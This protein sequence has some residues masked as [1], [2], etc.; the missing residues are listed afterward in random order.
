M[1]ANLFELWCEAMLRGWD[2][3]PRGGWDG[4]GHH[5]TAGI[6]FV[7]VVARAGGSF[8]VAPFGD[9]PDVFDNETAALALALERQTVWDAERVGFVAN[10]LGTWW[11]PHDYAGLYACISRE[12]LRGQLV[13]YLSSP[14]LE[15]PLRA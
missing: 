9:P 5:P 6:R 1:S 14:R 10:P 4:P 13:A 2:R 8:S 7:H 3:G 11:P 12:S 15:W